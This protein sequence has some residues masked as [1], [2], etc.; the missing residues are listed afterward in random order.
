MTTIQPTDVLYDWIGGP[1]AGRTMFP[2]P[3]KRR[4]TATE[5]RGLTVDVH[6]ND[7]RC[8][9]VW[10]VVDSAFVCRFQETKEEDR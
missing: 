7:V 6:V 2:A 9:Y 3:L 5:L 1:L 4:L 8:V 10:S